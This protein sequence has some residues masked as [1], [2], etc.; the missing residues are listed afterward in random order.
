M[1]APSAAL[2]AARLEARLRAVAR[3]ERAEQERRYLKSDLEF[4]GATVWQ[5]RAAVKELLAGLEEDL[6]HHRLIELAEILWREPMHERR[7][8]AVVLLEVRSGLLSVG[9][10]PFIER[11]IRESR[12]W[13][14]VD[15]LAADVVGDILSADEEGTLPVLDRWAADHDFWVRRSA[16]LAWLRPLRRGAPLDHFVGMADAM[17][18]ERE[19]F[20]RKAIGW[21]L[22]EVGKRR[23]E[24]VA[25]WLAPRTHRVSGVTIR[26]AVKYLPAPVRAELM[27]AYRERRPA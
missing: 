22:R 19:F 26:E 6:D 17:L 18:D 25:A 27:T 14:L 8:A 13:A 4:L 20:I 7:M 3:P 23:P 15:G 2:L 12:T 10:L 1:T 24:P 21:V 9:D 16:L 11:L 5:I